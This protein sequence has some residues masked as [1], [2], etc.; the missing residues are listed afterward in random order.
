MK[1]KD[2][3]AQDIVLHEAVIRHSRV[4][5][6][7]TDG[8]REI[9]LMHLMKVLPDLFEP[10]FVSTNNITSASF[11]QL[12]KLPKK[13]DLSDIQSNAIKDLLYFIDSA[14]DDG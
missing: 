2:I 12:L 10:L 5:S 9:G 3:I 11:K 8:L 14:S 13:E 1:T 6:H 7:F 4:M